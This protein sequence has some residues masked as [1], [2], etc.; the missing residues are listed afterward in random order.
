MSAIR[1]VA[2]IGVVKEDEACVVKKEREIK[3]VN[4]TGVAEIS[5]DKMCQQ[6][7]GAVEPDGAT[8]LGEGP[9]C[10]Y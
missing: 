10:T 8:D 7:K 1:L 3:D 4:V 5:K 2:D 9:I 6:C